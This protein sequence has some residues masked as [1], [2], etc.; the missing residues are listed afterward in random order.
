MR[1]TAPDRLKLYTRKGDN[2]PMT[3]T[4]LYEVSDSVATITMNRPEKLN[5]IAT[6]MALQIGELAKRVNVDRN[7]RVVVLTGSGERAFCAG[8]D[9][10]ALD[11][12]STPWELRGRP[13]YTDYIRAI[14]KPV[15]AAVHGYAYGGG[16]ELA[17][18]C[19]IR[20]CS[21][22]ASFAAPEIKL[23]WSGGG[24]MS[25]LL[26]RSIGPSNAGVMV[27]TGEPI[28]AVTAKSWGLVSE[29]Y[30]A[31]SLMPR[32]LDL[33]RAIARNAPIATEAG[34]VNLRATESIPVDQCIQ[35]ERDLQTFCFTT[36]DAT[37]GRK[38]FAEKRAPIFYGR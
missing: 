5:A 18:S 34:K 1:A 21:T 24:G 32:A 28:D 2:E 15:I 8:S 29:V 20:I 31:E 13:G 17:L 27:L 16:L 36:E 3:D 12:F 38:A 33:A 6:E 7:V 19:D 30:E 4:I 11:E 26:T 22:S 14:R 9:V 23:G 35:Y 25:A 37:E 10:N